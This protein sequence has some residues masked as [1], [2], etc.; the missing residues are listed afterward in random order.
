MATHGRRRALGQHF[1]MDR[2][3]CD[4]IAETALSLAEETRSEA[5]LEIGPG[6]GALTEPLLRMIEERSAK[7]QLQEF[8]I[9]ER[10]PRIAALWKDRAFPI[11]TRVELG[12]FLELPEPAWLGRRPLTVLS[13]L[14]YS[15]GTAILIRLARQRAAIPVMVLMFQAEVARRLRAEPDT[16]AWGSLSIWIQN[17]WDVTRLAGVPPRSFS[18]PPKV[19]SEVVV[20]RRRETLRVEIP[21]NA[22]AEQCW[23]QLLKACF[24]HRRKMLRSGLPKSGP[25]RNALE[26]SQVDDTKRAEALTWSEWNR[27]Y[28]ALSGEK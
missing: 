25:L 26:L 3:L 21:A 6:K 5:L 14:P 20:L 12:D 28:N 18:P 7:I 10:D 24:A 15:T 13:N 11:P 23:D 19:D 27:L 8:I 16:K 9:S 17:Q 1:L 2:A 22:R 4:R